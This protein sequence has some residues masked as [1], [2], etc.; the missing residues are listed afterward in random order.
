MYAYLL[1][2]FTYSILILDTMSSRAVLQEGDVDA[3]D[4]DEKGFNEAPDMF[5]YVWES[6]MVCRVIITDNKKWECHHCNETFAVHNETKALMHVTKTK[7]HNSKVCHAAIETNL[8]SQ[9]EDLR[10]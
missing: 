10:F 2:S 9:Y 5:N 1:N 7:G 3:D 4:A 8:M 6:D